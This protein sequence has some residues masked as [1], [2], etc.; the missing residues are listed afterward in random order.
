MEEK[1]EE[2]DSLIQ[3]YNAC[4]VTKNFVDPDQ[5][6]VYLQDAVLKKIFRK[7]AT[8]KIYTGAHGLPDGELGET[9]EKTLA[10]QQNIRSF[11][12]GLQND[13]ETATVIKEM[14]YNIP[15]LV[16]VGRSRGIKSLRYDHEYLLKG[17]LKTL[18][19]NASSPDFAEPIV[20]FLAFCWSDKNELTNFMRELGII[21]VATMMD[22]SGNITKGK[23]FLL[24]KHQLS[25]IGKS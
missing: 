11:I 6:A 2:E 17:E 9:D 22:D 21:S 16:L 25:L 15:P 23:S 14:N 7:S 12:S 18:I 3:C 20:F 4:I 5:V 1:E 10:M 8:I 19:R 13:T 24:D